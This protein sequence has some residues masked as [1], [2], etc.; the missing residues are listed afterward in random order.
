MEARYHI[1]ADEIIALYCNAPVGVRDFE[2][3]FVDNGSGHSIFLQQ[4]GKPETLVTVT[5]E[6]KF[7]KRVEHDE[8]GISVGGEV[9]SK[10]S[11]GL[12][13]AGE[14]KEGLPKLR[15]CR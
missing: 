15:Y 5:D 3:V 9:P 13:S 6:T 1:T 11:G 2:I 8:P 4:V 12:H 7:L 14:T 10:E